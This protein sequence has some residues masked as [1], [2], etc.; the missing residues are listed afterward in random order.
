MGEDFLNSQ[1]AA[2]YLG[3]SIDQLYKLNAG[4]RIP[5]YRPSGGKI[6]YLKSDLVD[7]IIAGR[8]ATTK[9]IEARAIK[10]L[11]SKS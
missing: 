1:E 11:K 3:I 6:Y 4:S 2:S 9:G 10:S 5:T 7:W 8:R